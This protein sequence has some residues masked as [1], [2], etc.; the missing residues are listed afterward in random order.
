M[1]TFSHLSRRVAAVALFA[2][3]A[4]VLAACGA[5]PGAVT[6]DD[7]SKGGETAKVTLIEY[8]SVT[9]AHCAEFNETVMP[10]LEE[11]FIKT[12]KIKYVYREF[13]TPPNDVSAAGILLARCAGKDKYFEVV[14]TIMKSQREMFAGNSTANARPVLL[15]IAKSVGM[16]E[17]QFN[18]C[19]T[20]QKGI[21]R[22][23][24]NVDKY[25][26]E[27]DVSSTP[28]F[29]INGKKFERK[30]GDFAEF[31]KALLDAGVK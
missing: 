25:M 20:D 22:I 3:S 12:G 31:E 26:K 11:K 23:Q 14:D 7:M 30:T 9:C 18:T 2:A 28:T 29:F 16:S 8:A 13:L 1:Q 15:N 4:L 24:N 5:K 27:N 6:A 19:I 10:Q 21:E 17:D